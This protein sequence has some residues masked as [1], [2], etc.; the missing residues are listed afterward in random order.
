MNKLFVVTYPVP[1]N[2]I[3]IIDT[4]KPNYLIAV[5]AAVSFVYSLGIK[6]DLAVGD[7]DSI[8]DG[9][10]LDN[11]KKI[12]LNP[13]KDVTDTEYALDLAI[14]MNF[15][16]IY[17]VGGLGGKRYEHGYANLNLIKRYKKIKLI[18][19]YSIISCLEIGTYTLNKNNNYYSMF[20][21][22]ES[23]ITL[24]GFKYNVEDFNINPN[25]TIGISNEISDE[26]ARIIVKKGEIL[27]FNTKK[28]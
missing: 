21:E 23:V 11:M 6:I 7:F 16:E 5:D 17:L 9:K 19:E 10:I 20:A 3:E 8:K 2:L 4:Y 24:K 15:A 25:D 18:T 22:K 27:L 1:N 26:N 28:D 13:I 12:E 14:R